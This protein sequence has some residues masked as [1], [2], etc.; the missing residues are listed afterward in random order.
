M[1][2][3]AFSWFRLRRADR[4]EAGCEVDVAEVPR[5]GFARLLWTAKRT[6]GLE[7]SVAYRLLEQEA[8]ATN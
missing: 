1:R 2:W 5:Q 8:S 6:L 7:S 4:Y 3:D